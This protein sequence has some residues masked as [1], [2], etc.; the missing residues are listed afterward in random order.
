MDNVIPMHKSPRSGPKSVLLSLLVTV[1]VAAI[2]YYVQLPALNIKSPELYFF[3]VFLLVVY[4]VALAI[5]S[6]GR[7]RDDPKGFALFLKGH[8]KVPLV[9]LALIIVVVAIGALS[10][11]LI[12]RAGDYSELLTPANSDFTTDVNQISYDQIPMLDKDSADRLGDRKLGE[13]SDMVSQFEVSDAYTQI[14]YNDQ[15]VRVTYLEYADFFKWL[16]NRSDGLPAYIYIDMVTQ[17]VDVVRL[18]EGMKYSPAEYF[19]RY[20]LRH[21]RFQYPTLM[22]EECTLEIDE[23][24]H[25]WWIC[26]VVDRTIGLFGGEDIIGAVLVDAVTGE[27]SYLPIDEIPT[28]VD[29]VYS[30][31]L[32]IRQYNWHG[33]YQGGF[34][35]SLFGQK[36]CTM[37]TEGYNY[38]ALEDDVWLY[39]GVTSVTSDASNIGFILVNQRTKEARYYPVAGATEQSAQ[40]SA[41]G[42][43]QHLK[44]KATFP[45]LLNISNE[46]TYFIALKDDASLVKMYAMVNVRQYQIVATGSS[47]AECEQNYI[48]L[49]RQNGIA[50]ESSVIAPTAATV[51]GEVTDLRSAVISGTTYYYVEIDGCYYRVSAADSEAI[52]LT[53][54][55]DELTL[56]LTGDVDA[57]IPT[58]IL[59]N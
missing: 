29:R 15:P 46:P 16:S 49:L 36:N 37:T 13:L 44:Y 12:F 40:S 55:G 11:A 6:G 7:L 1:I 52:V 21:L 45:L 9:I 56:A 33:M 43:V 17:E 8:C 57:A 19:N 25:P 14:N 53:D 39:T 47:V 32:V 20:L 31:N 28:W 27:S 51:S 4:V 58:A 22:F 42:V 48:E 24:G 38:I 50:A 54:I 26:S 5:F 59:Q 2:Y 10:S 41:V 30:A 23:Q 34:W 18:A 35:N 3:L